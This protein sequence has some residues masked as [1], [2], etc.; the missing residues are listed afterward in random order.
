MPD[1][2]FGKHLG[3]KLCASYIKRLGFERFPLNLFG[4]IGHTANTPLNRLG[5]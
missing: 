4:C 3:D 1:Y 2:G 5:Q